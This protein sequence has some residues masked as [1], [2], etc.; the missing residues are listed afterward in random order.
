MSV[1]ETKRLPPGYCL[2]YCGA[3]LKT[4]IGTLGGELGHLAIPQ[5]L[6]E[7]CITLPPSIGTCVL[8]PAI[9]QTVRCSLRTTPTVGVRE[10]RPAS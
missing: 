3:D 9:W 8:S 1:D 10:F 6:S 2:S 5:A 7:Q 4:Q